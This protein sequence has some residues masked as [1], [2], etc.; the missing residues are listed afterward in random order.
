MLRIAIIG[1]GKIADDHAAQLRRV[2]GCL[3]VGACDR[4]RLM[5]GQLCDRFGIPQAYD[6]AARMLEATRPDIVH[7][8]T[9]PGSHHRLGRLCLDAG[10]HVY[11]EKPFAVTVEETADLLAH[12]ERCRRKI[13]VGHD[14]QFSH[15]MRRA[16]R[17]IRGG[18]LGGKPLHMESTYCY[19]L[20]DPRYARALLADKGHWIRELPGKLLHNIISHGI[21]RIAEHMVSDA[22]EVHAF[23]HVSQTLRDLGEDG[24]VDEL[25]AVIRDADGATAY[26]TFSSQMQ[27]SL[28]QF[29][30]YGNRN[31]LLVD[32]D[33]QTVIRLRGPR[34]KSYAG[35]FLP[36]LLQ[37]GQYVGNLA[38]N[39]GRFLA[40]DFHMKSGMKH[41]IEGFQAAVRDEAP[42]PIPYREILLTARIMADIFART[43]A[44]GHR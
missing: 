6:D 10:A 30:V 1:C 11:M 32:E 5:A 2:A 23:G 39:A 3:L 13:T 20:G 21:A 12:A 27:P 44:G 8:T 36:P 9:P 7:V 19:D 4:E 42:V 41:L 26:F 18:Y 24:I 34:F 16:R 43:G 14:L 15:A 25:R 37:A 29:R 35:K 17:L 40:N 33:E 22:P 31:G 28:N 38:G